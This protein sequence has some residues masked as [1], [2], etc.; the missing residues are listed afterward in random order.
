MGSPNPSLRL[1]LGSHTSQSIIFPSKDGQW[2]LCVQI[3]R[4]YLQ[5]CTHV[6]NGGAEV[7]PLFVHISFD[8]ITLG[9]FLGSVYAR[10]LHPLNFSFACMATAREQREIKMSFKEKETMMIATPHQI[11][12]FETYK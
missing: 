4:L 11:D 1:R 8:A 6:F 2:C 12:E 3:S 7:I 10:V 5:L 9:P